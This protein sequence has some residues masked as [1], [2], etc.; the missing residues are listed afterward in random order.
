MSSPRRLVATVVY[1]AARNSRA[2][3]WPSPLEQ[4]V[5]RTG[6]VAATA[7]MQGAPN[8]CYVRRCTAVDTDEYAGRPAFNNTFTIH[9][10]IV[11]A[12]LRH[13]DTT[14]PRHLLARR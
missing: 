13:G 14:W 2:L 11:M 6:P 5:I 4:P 10:L 9:S 7:G 8:T 1:P 12:P 3:A